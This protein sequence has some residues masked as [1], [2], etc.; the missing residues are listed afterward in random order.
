MK[1][2][3]CPIPGPGYVLGPHEYEYDENCIWCGKPRTDRG[4]EHDGHR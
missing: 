2:E 1:S 3:V 4:D